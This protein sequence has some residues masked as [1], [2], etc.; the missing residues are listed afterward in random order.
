MGGQPG[1]RARRGGVID[2]RPASG[3]I[4][5]PSAPHSTAVLVVK[6]VHSGIFLAEL[7]AIVWLFMTGLTGRRDRTVAIAAAA[8][9]GEAVVFLGN[10]RTCPL[11]PLTERLGADRGAVSDIFLPG[12]VARTIPA[13]SSV[14]VT[15]AALLHARG[16]IRSR[17]DSVEP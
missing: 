14:I 12:V 13:W 6:T 4:G 5:R 11:T 7:A 10:G 15:V 8:V 9:A 17:G 1:R 2:P 16:I 3:E